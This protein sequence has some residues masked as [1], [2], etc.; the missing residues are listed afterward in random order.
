M[1]PKTKSKKA[2]KGKTSAVVDG[3]S[4]EEMSKDQL[5]EHIVRLREEL[6]REREERSYFQLERDKIQAFWEVAKRSLEETKA[7]LRNRLREREEAEERHRV[8]VTVYKQ[9]LKHVLSEHHDT[10]SGLKMDGVA[11]TSLIQNQHAE[12]ELGLRRERHGLQAD[13]REKRLHNQNC[14]KELKLKHQVELMELASGYDRRIREIEVKYHNKMQ[15]MIEAE[16]KRQR[17]EVNALEDAMKSRVVALVEDHDRALRGAEE[18]Y[19]AIQIKLLEDQKQLK[20]ELAEVTKQQARADKELSAGQQE[21]KR[22]SES[23]QEAQQK[24]PELRRQ[25]EEYKQ[26]QAKMAATR[27]QAKVTEKELRDLTVDHELLLQAFEKVQRER[28][29]LLRRQTEAVLD[30]QRRSGLKELLLERKLA[31]LTDTL[32]KKEA[33]LCAALSASSIDQTATNRLEEILESKG[34]TVG[35]FQSDLAR[36]CKE[37]DDLLQACKEKLTALGVPLHDFHFRSSQQILGG[38]TRAQLSPGPA[39]KP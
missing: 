18:Y 31:A 13:L 26:A 36:E 38:P 35:A 39:S 32:E 1:P 8:E 17:A 15:S 3:L 34:V 19:A 9:K 21:N 20:E 10:T 28:D 7:E 33:E 16:G 22:L 4:T 23:L 12:S 14:I 30:V 11:S 29:E 2:A 37:Y 27:A 24:L 6:D 25:L 5:E